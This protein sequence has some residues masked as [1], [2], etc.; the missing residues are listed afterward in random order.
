MR[1]IIK[2]SGIIPAPDVHFTNTDKV[3]LRGQVT[4]SIIMCGM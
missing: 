1:M 3:K 4:T 2:I